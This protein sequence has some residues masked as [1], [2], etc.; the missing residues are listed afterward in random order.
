VTPDE[1]GLEGRFGHTKSSSP[2]DQRETA[3]HGPKRRC[4]IVQ[5]M[6]LEFCELDRGHDRDSAGPCGQG[7]P[8]GNGIE[9]AAETSQEMRPVERDPFGCPW[10]VECGGSRRSGQRPAPGTAAEVGW[11]SRRPPRIVL[12][13]VRLTGGGPRWGS[14]WGASHRLLRGSVD[15]DVEAIKRFGQPPLPGE[16][17]GQPGKIAGDCLGSPT[18]VAKPRLEERQ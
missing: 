1:V 5:A 12:D 8:G 2:I 13:R 17:A 11:A 18:R 3:E 9:V 4:T 6:L 15:R 7:L 14:G 10:R 16:G